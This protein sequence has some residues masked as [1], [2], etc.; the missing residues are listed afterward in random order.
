M[1]YY[2]MTRGT[3]GSPLLA[4]EEETCPACVIDFLSV[5]VAVTVKCKPRAAMPLK[6][7]GPEQIHLFI[8]VELIACVNGEKTPL[9]LLGVL[10]P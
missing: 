10:L 7:D 2:I 3:P 1:P 9:L 5:P 4:V 8:L 6:L